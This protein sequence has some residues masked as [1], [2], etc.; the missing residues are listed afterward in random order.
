MAGVLA[1]LFLPLCR[2]LEKK[3]PRVLAALICLLVLLLFMAGV[4][5][6]IGWQVSE[7]SKDFD[8]LKQKMLEAFNRIQ[9]FVSSRFGISIAEQS[10]LLK[11]QKKSVG[12]LVE[13]M[14]GTFMRIFTGFI[15]MLVYVVLFLYF[16]GHIKNFILKLFPPAQQPQAEQVVVE[17]AG[18]S[19][20]YLVGLVKMIFCL[21]ILYSI[22]FSI[23]GA[24]NPIF[25]AV[26][27]GLLEIV[28]FIGNLTGTTITVF[29]SA[30]HGSSFGVLAGI[31][32]TYG[33]VQFIQG[34]V[35]EPLIVGTQVKINPF[36]T[37]VALVIG[38][39]LWGIPG[40][41][42]AIPLTAMLKIVCD[43]IEPLKPYG[44]L[45]GEIETQRKEPKF[46]K[47]LKSWV[48]KLRK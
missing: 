38:E 30:V 39:I 1:T 14:G 6:L 11:D 22:G 4:G 34:W 9:Q 15:L 27:C 44:F 2:Y 7:L 25:F 26:L 37:I 40:V 8:L 31:V 33:L 19:Q 17:A 12:G 23:A 41:I 45:I 18:V 29:V 35:L 3:M 42:L 24:K 46:F 21:W 10:Q 36:A 32:I 13:I 16:R 48:A 43:H 28:P 5:A 47:K 20:Q